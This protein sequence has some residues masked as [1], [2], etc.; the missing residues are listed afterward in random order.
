MPVQ[1]QADSEAPSAQQVGSN[2]TISV[3][4][5]CPGRVVFFEAGNSEGWIATDSPLELD[6]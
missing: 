5:T 1:S 3:C 6:R 4:E 2:P